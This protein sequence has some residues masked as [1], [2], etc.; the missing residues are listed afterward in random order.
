[1]NTPF[2]DLLRFQTDFAQ[3]GP[4]RFLF[5]LL[6]ALVYGLTLS[7]IYQI[8]YR[9]NEPQDISI[10]RSFPLMAPAVTTIFWLI[11]FSLPLSLGLLGALSFVRFRTPIKRAED[12]AHI[13]LLIAGSLACA[14]GQFI[15]TLILVLLVAAFGYARRSMPQLTGENNNFAIISVHSNKSFD[16]HDLHKQIAELDSKTTLVN[17]TEQDG[18]SSVVFNIPKLGKETQSQITELIKAVDESARIDI[19]FPENQ[20]SAY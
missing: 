3:G 19:F 4:D 17:A 6:A 7:T 9:S 14:V 10:S 8:Y 13:L 1:M 5:A 2:T 11:Q 20:I 18:L 15:S 16:I 12:I